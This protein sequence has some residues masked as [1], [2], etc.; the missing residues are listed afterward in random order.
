[1]DAALEFF[2]RGS[3]FSEVLFDHTGDLPGLEDLTHRRRTRAR[4]AML[5]SRYVTP[6]G[7][8]RVKLVQ[9]LDDGGTPAAP[10]GAGLGRSRHLRGVRACSRRPAG[11]QGTRGDPRLHRAHGTRQRLGDPLRRERRPFLCGDPGGGKIEII[12][13]TGHLA[14]SPRRTPPR[15]A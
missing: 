15:R 5:E 13:W 9:V 8:G 14:S 12:E 3:G 2:G 6:L 4:V 10:A 11:A 1:M 7:P